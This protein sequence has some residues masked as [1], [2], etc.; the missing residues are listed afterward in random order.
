[1]NFDEHDEHSLEEYDSLAEPAT[2][3]GAETS[4]SISLDEHFGQMI[5]H[6]VKGL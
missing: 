4:F 2:I 6:S 3:P 1:V 5:S